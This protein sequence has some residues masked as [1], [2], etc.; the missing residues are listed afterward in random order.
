MMH[1]TAM[2]LIADF[3]GLCRGYGGVLAALRRRYFTRGE[4]LCAS[5]RRM[6][7]RHAR[8]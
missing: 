5:G 6:H 7:T 2:L 8:P 3:A 4:R 1:L